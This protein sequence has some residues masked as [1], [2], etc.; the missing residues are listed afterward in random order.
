MPGTQSSQ[1]SQ[2]IGNEK[3]SSKIKYIKKTKKMPF[4]QVVRIDEVMTFV[5]TQINIERISGRV[6]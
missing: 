4:L 6:K 3:T 2:R 1:Q 5:Y